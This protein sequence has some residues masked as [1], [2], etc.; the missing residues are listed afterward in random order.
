MV[1]IAAQGAVHGPTKERG[2][3]RTTD[4]GATWSKILYVD[5]NTGAADLSMD[6]NNP[7]VLYAGMWEHR[8]FPWT[9]QSGGPGS[10]IY[11]SMDG[12]DTWEELTKG[13]PEEM[14][15]V[16]VDVS[17]ANSNRVFANIES[18]PEKG[19]VFRS[20]DAG[21]TWKHVCKDRVTIARSWYCLLY[22]SPSP[23]D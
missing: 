21:K 2:V 23:R 4:G 1:Y 19:G 8:R 5:E 9:V 10:G 12:G 22:T 15:K 17:P 16:A 3:Y 11:K 14:G 6:P 20:D 7:R 18:H 13:L